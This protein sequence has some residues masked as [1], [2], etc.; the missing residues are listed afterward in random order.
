M[1][2]VIGCLTL[3]TFEEWMLGQ[4]TA[5]ELLT[6]QQRDKEGKQRSGR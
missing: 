6:E 1:Q 4:G 3:C 2:S 5:S